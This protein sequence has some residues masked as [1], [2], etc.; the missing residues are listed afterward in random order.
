MLNIKQ[1]AKSKL[2]SLVLKAVGIVVAKNIVNSRNLIKRV[3]ILLDTNKQF[4]TERK[5]W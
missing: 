3:A 4:K 2:R 5:K 1:I